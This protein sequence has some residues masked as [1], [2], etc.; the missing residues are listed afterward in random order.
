MIRV[1]VA[2]D[3]PILR[4]GL[5]SLGNAGGSPFQVVGE[6]SNCDEVLSKLG[7]LNPEVLVIDPA[8]NCGEGIVATQ[9]IRSKYPDVR[10]LVFS[11]SYDDD[12]FDNVLKAGIQGFLRN[13]A[14]LDTI[15][16][17]IRLVASGHVLLS[18]L[19]TLR[20]L[21]EFQD[22]KHQDLEVTY[23]PSPREIEVL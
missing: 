16:E 15:A 5:M 4:R 8:M 19:V 10:I 17:A 11:R 2:D 12:E 18:P 3:Q 9:A 1:L 21:H 22:F 6:A 23:V 13:T 20:L 7:E 14:E